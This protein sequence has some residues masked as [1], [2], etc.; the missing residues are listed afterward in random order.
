[1]AREE[2][3][4]VK[5]CKERGGVNWYLCR[6]I[7]EYEGR[8]W[9]HNLNNGSMPVKRKDSVEFKDAGSYIKELAAK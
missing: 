2:F 7:A 8:I 9:M 1:L 3:M 4:E 6:I 5:M